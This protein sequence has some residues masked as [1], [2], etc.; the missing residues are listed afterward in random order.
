MTDICRVLCGGGSEVLTSRGGGV[1]GLGFR[2]CPHHMPLHEAH[3]LSSAGGSPLSTGCSL[4]KA[5][6]RERAT[7]RPLRQALH[8]SLGAVVAWRKRGFHSLL[9]SKPSARAL[10]VHQEEHL[11]LIYTWLCTGQQD[12]VLTQLVLDHSW[13]P[14]ETP[15]FCHDTFN[16]K[17]RKL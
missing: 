5:V 16:A 4:T 1:A 9:K 15:S 11:F 17:T 7:S 6:W 2:S 10:F 14:L 13:T 8:P 3:P 12:S